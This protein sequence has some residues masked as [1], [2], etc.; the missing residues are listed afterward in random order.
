MST[1]EDTSEE[2]SEASKR[3][4]Y[5]AGPT[6]NRNERPCCSHGPA[7]L[8]TAQEPPLTTSET[9]GLAQ[10]QIAAVVKNVVNHRASRTTMGP[11]ES[12]AIASFLVGS[13]VNR[14]AFFALLTDALEGGGAALGVL[15]LRQV[16]WPTEVH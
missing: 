6:R 5:V 2:H 4:K 1:Y 8:K 14:H 10:A 7:V 3:S 11:K 12:E 9:N 13:E 15:E 16:L